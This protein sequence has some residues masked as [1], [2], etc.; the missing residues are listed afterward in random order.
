MMT[1]SLELLIIA[2]LVAANGM[3]AMAEIAVVAARKA[4]L[5]QRA[6]EG[7][8]GARAALQ[9]TA[10]PNRFLS[11]IQIGITLIGIL[12]GAF[13]GATVA[14]EIAGSL[15]S[16]T[17]LAPYSDTIGIVAVVIGI[18]FLVL[19]IGELVP[20]RLALNNAERIASITAVPLQILSR[21]AAP[22]VRLLS[23]STELVL[24]A[25]RSAP[26]AEP[27]VTEEEIRII[28]E[29][30]A[31]AGVVEEAEQ[32]M[33]ESIFR[34]GD[35][36]VSALMTPRTEIVWLDADDP[37]DETRLR[38]IQ[39]IHSR[40]PVAQ[41][42]LD[43][44]LGVVEVKD[45]LTRS[46]RN[47]PIDLT[48]CLREPPYVPETMRALRALELFKQTGLQI[49]LV[50]DEHGGVQG[51]VTLTDILEEIVG[52][53]ATAKEPAEPQA[54]QRED[55]SWLMDGALTAE[56]FRE[57]LDVKEMRREE[58]PGYRTLGGLVLLHL[59]HIPAAG[60]SFE[61]AG[62]RFEVVDMDGNRVDK[63]LVSRP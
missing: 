21:I 35:R 43:N 58:E 53:I 44:I 52:D 2:L 34:F 19:V 50:L 15:K 32:D 18:T 33:V 63:V 25:L 9:L 24:R 5:Q 47:E 7:D 54:E 6:D 41:G 17:S 16:V 46:L 1:I 37:V 20:K 40:F 11:T 51:L 23:V 14:R 56:E 28:I 49:A 60:E 48:A 10:E 27:P 59:G 13:G 4:R 45:I 30:A 3:L 36:K 57:L 39:S 29:Q 38:M 62:L 22:L 12:A 8:R 26:S 31:Q 42:R 55:G 61:R